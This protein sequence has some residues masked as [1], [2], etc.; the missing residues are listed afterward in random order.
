MHRLRYLW[1][2]D[3]ECIVCAVQKNIIS[4]I[5]GF[6]LVYSSRT[7]YVDVHHCLCT[8]RKVADVSRQRL[9]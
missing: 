3:K 7:L 5:Y 6:A 8:R 4:K 2:V 1:A 9:P